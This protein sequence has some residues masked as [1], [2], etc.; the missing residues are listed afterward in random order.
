MAN[1]PTIRMA[2]MALLSVFS[3]IT[4][5]LLIYFC[6][7]SPLFIDPSWV[8]GILVAIVTIVYT[9]GSTLV[10]RTPN[11]RM[12]TA[13]VE[14]AVF[15]VLWVLWLSISGAL[16]ANPWVVC[17]NVDWVTG[18]G[19]CGFGQYIAARTLAWFSFLVAS[20][21]TCLVLAISLRARSTGKVDVWRMPIGDLSLNTVSQRAAHP[22]AGT[23]GGYPSQYPV[24]QQP[25]S[26][27]V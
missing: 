17:A 18:D 4:A 24:G 27:T 20:G 23:Y 2:M 16:T 11:A 22:N 5:A 12:I 13:M 3:L 10:L 15:S 14:V 25:M 1:L 6:A 8:V 19:S 7:S 26:Q 21:W 9:V